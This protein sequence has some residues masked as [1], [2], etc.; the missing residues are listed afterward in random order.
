M[1]DLGIN[2]GF[3]GLNLLE[4][5][6]LPKYRYSHFRLQ[7]DKKLGPMKIHYNMV[8][9]SIWSLNGGYVFRSGENYLMRSL[10]AI[11]EM[12]LSR[13][14]QSYFFRSTISRNRRTDT[15]RAPLSALAAPISMAIFHWRI[16]SPQPRSNRLS[17]S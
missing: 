16:R 3:D 8:E 7:V 13:S 12:Y 4:M 1:L 11:Y 14:V 2:Q 10:R 6:K 9:K 15:G 5:E 17:G